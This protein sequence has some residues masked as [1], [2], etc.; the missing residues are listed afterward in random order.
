MGETP[1]QV[2]YLQSASNFRPLQ[3]ISIPPSG[4]IFCGGRVGDGSA[5]VGH[6]RGGGG[7][8]IALIAQ[9]LLCVRRP[10]RRC[11]PRLKSD[12]EVCQLPGQYVVTTGPRPQIAMGK[13][14][15]VTMIASTARTY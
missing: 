10:E 4:Q 15:S 5:A 13:L 6:A 1:Y 11:A 12:G 8:V 9:S 2:V 3:N 7:S 14:V